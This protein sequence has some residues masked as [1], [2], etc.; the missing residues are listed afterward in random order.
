M[1]EVT[2]LRA[3]VEQTGIE[4][5]GPT[6]EVLLPDGAPPTLELIEAYLREASDR[7]DE[8]RKGR[9]WHACIE[10]RAISF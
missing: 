10:G 1:A 6:C 3:C 9:V 7:L 2:H 4:R 8:T 5:M